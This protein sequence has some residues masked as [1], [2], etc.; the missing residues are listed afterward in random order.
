MQLLSSHI[1]QNIYSLV[2]WRMICCFCFLLTNIQEGR[3]NRIDSL[4]LALVKTNNIERKA[5]IYLVLAETVKTRSA[6]SGFNYLRKAQQIIGN[7][8]TL[9]FLGQA[10]QIYGDIWNFQGDVQRSLSEYKAALFCFQRAGVKKQQM[11]L[12]NMI[13]NSYSSSGNFAEALKFY[14]NCKEIAENEKDADMLARLDNNVGKIYAETN[15]FIKANEYYLKAICAFEKTNDSIKRATVELNL[16][17]NYSEI[18]DQDLANKYL[19]KASS[20]LKT[21]D[22]KVLSGL[23]SNIHAHSFFIQKRYSEALQYLFNSLQIVKEHN[24]EEARGP[25]QILM[26]RILNNIGRAYYHLGD[27]RLAKN[28]LLAGYRLSESLNLLS[29]NVTAADH[30]SHSYEKTGQL[31]SSIYYLRIFKMKSDSLLAI[32]SINVLKLA[33]VKMEYEKEAK[34]KRIQLA[35]NKVIQRRNQIIFIAIGSSLFALILILMLKLKIESQK[36]R[37]LQIEKK[38]AQLEKKAADA[39]LET[40]N[41]ELVTKVMHTTKVNEM[42]LRIAEK[43]KKM[44]TGEES[45]NS[46]IKNDLIKELLVSTNKDENWKEFEIRFQNVQVDFYNRLR[47]KFPDLTTSEIRLCAFLKLNMSTKEISAITYQS[48]RSIVVARYRLRIKLGLTTTDNLTL[49]LSQL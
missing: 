35:Y 48:E 17:A 4:H 42:V 3:A 23:S 45:A 36:K 7:K 20:V 21:I 11:I 32:Q 40:Q 31:D 46:R 25:Q 22:K 28:Y 29:D 10:H 26:A 44:E 15:D 33:E 39:M 49:F 8:A 2:F 18:G 14:L 6:D 37:Q 24:P 47:E 19:V 16:A 38:H 41:K 1:M 5:N 27:Y 43:L 34:E 9:A 13:G 12:L 30:L